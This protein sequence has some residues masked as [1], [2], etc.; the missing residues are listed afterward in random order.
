[1]S[2]EHFVPLPG[3]ER[4]AARNLV[5]GTRVA[6]SERIGVTVVL[7]R[8]AEL[9][10][11]VVQGLRTLS[12]KDLGESYG[13]DPAD[14]ERVVNVLGRF[15]VEVSEIDARSRR[16]QVEGES[17][18]LLRAF[19][20]AL[21][22]RSS[23]EDGAE[24]GYRYRTGQLHIPAELDGI[25]IAVLG[26]DNRPQAQARLRFVP[27]R[28]RS[29]SYTPLQLAE[30]YKFP[31]ETDGTGQRLAI[32]ELGGGYSDRELQQYFATLGISAP[33]VTAVSVD[34]ARNAPEGNPNG[35]DG[36]V[37][38]DVEIAGAMANGAHLLVY[39]APNSDQGFLNAVSA[40]AHATPA[41]TAISI[42]WGSAE[43]A[44]TAQAREAMNQAFAD[45]AALGATVTA[46]A[47]DAGS[48]DGDPSGLPETDFPASSP[49]VL[50]CGGT[51]L[52][53]NGG[54]VVSETVWNGEPEGGATGG[55]VSRAFPRPQ[56]QAN[57][58]VPGKGRGVPDVA[59]V[60][61]P[62]T[63]YEILVDGH[64][65]VV[66]GTS[67]VAPL[68]AALVCRLAQALGRPLGLF[69]PQIYPRT[70][71]TTAL[72]GFR[73]ITQGNNG[74]YSAG[75]GW[76]ACTGLGVPVGQALLDHVR[77]QAR[78]AGA[79]KTPAAQA[80]TRVDP[81]NWQA[82]EEAAR[83]RDLRRERPPHWG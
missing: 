36:E 81:E 10:E 19:G 3:S 20:C 75:P 14:V 16:I 25:V 30:I 38:L 48:S 43:N 59:A 15:G 8:R 70:P 2:E 47:G 13:A 28:A 37:V 60:A 49:Y 45:A 76:D 66:G 50:A 64:T 7:R 73:D 80:S 71:G 21:F 79:P 61:D 34:G 54:S 24:P 40:A 12:G 51:R 1:M 82:G 23:T 55:G 17:Q 58:D 35:A 9:P 65:T 53:A 69:Q 39:F 42:S 74:A 5:A 46:A 57:V 41:P 77:G 68:W 67:A 22:Q 29:V 27:S 31:S 4:P 26:L 6:D 44:W 83:E 33:K 52:I 63:G 78:S 72:P 62:A 32:I 18:A 56:W 11:D